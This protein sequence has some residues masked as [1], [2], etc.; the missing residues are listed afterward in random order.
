MSCIYLRLKIAALAMSQEKKQPISEEENPHLSN[1]MFGL[2]LLGPINEGGQQLREIFHGMLEGIRDRFDYY[3]G[4]EL[5]VN[6]QLND[7]LLELRRMG[8]AEKPTFPEPRSVAMTVCAL[9]NK[10]DDDEYTEGCD[11]IVEF[12]NKRLDDWMDYV[13]KDCNIHFLSFQRDVDTLHFMEKVLHILDVFVASQFG[14][15]HGVEEY[16]PIDQNE[17]HP[18]S[19]P[20]FSIGGLECQANE[21]CEC[22]CKMDHGIEVLQGLEDYLNGEDTSAAR[23]MQGVALA[24]DIRF[25]AGNEGEVFDKIKEMGKKAYESLLESFDAIMEM[26]SPEDSQARADKIIA[27]AD[28]NKKALQAMADKSVAINDAAKQGIIKLAEETDP[29]GKMKTAVNAISTAA[30]APRIIDSLLGLLR[31]EVSGNSG[32]VTKRNEAKKALD[33]LKKN[34]DG[35][36]Q[37]DEKNSDVVAANREKVKQGIADAKEALKSVREELKGHN[38]RMSGYDKAISGINPKIFSKATEEAETKE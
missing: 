34:T 21:S 22:G 20:D 17:L 32:L 11:A 14:A 29:T 5:K 27:K 19:T 1:L 8:W 7:Y 28:T 25:R 33:D 26:V 31:K 30:I 10:L 16:A 23:Y 2:G 13:T 37:G 36:S 18:V 3:D 38:K 15:R 4:S 35:A 9:G 12:A 6:K 24:N